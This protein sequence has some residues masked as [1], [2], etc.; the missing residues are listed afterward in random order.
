MVELRIQRFRVML[1]SL[2]WFS[3]FLSL[4]PSDGQLLGPWTQPESP[5]F[6]E[7]R[8]TSQII[9]FDSNA[10]TIWLI[11][12]YIT[13]PS[14]SRT[15]H[16]FNVTNPQ[17]TAHSSISNAVV[18]DSETYTQHNDTIYMIW[19]DHSTNAIST[20]NMNTQQ[21]T[22]KLEGS[23]FP[24]Y[25]FQEG[26]LTYHDGYLL[27]VGGRTNASV[28]GV[29]HNHFQI[30]RISDTLWFEGP[31]L[32]Q[33]RNR[34]TSAVVD[35][36]LY[37]IGGSTNIVIRIYIGDLE[38]ISNYQW[39]TLNDTLS[40]QYITDIYMRSVVYQSNIFVLGGYD[41]PIDVIH[42]DSL[43]VT[44]NI[45]TLI[46]NVRRAT[47]VV[48]HAMI[49][50][51]GG[52][53]GLC[54][55]SA[56]TPV[57]Y[58][59]APLLTLNPTED[60]TSIPSP[61][62]TKSPTS[63]PS[64]SPSSNSSELLVT[65]LLE[66]NQT[67]APTD[68]CNDN[69]TEISYRLSIVAND[70]NVNEISILLT[71]VFSEIDCVSTVDI[72]AVEDDVLVLDVITKRDSDLNSSE[73]E[74]IAIHSLDGKYDAEVTV[75]L[76]QEYGTE[77]SNGQTYDNVLLIIAGVVGIL[78]ILV[79]CGSLFLILDSL[80]VLRN[81]SKSRNS[82]NIDKQTTEPRADR[83]R[84]GTTDT[85]IR[86]NHVHERRTTEG[87]NNSVAGLLQMGPGPNI[88]ISTMNEDIR[89][90][91]DTEDLFQSQKCTK[92]SITTQSASTSAGEV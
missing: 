57:T 61:N 88:A 91:G 8:Y 7:D 78:L 46:S 19:D 1:V 72:I 39:E 56:Q 12:G 59:Y 90:R 3:F 23:T 35:D 15:V 9:G 53:C 52:W 40:E 16:S 26:A 4:V 81:S 54:N 14:T 36:Y 80:I 21:F 50:V 20:F 27:I 74:R 92:N 25:V 32:P 30:F 67:D 13:D 65:N 68:Q 34:H 86:A 42:T 38:N 17:F 73:I 64:E 82:S 48:A 69:T 83:P 79:C 33:N 43:T 77:N 47:A 58:Q 55:G 76:L 63:I 44:R 11:G 37:I 2:P 51:F 60:P 18:A 22:P 5:T 24:I 66:L 10:D 70:S 45:S 49:Y 28:A 84:S 87:N 6:P 85:V 89:R 75:V 31:E 71:N 41:A 62:P 29:A